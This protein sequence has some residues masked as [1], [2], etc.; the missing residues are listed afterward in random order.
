MREFTW[1]SRVGRH[2]QQSSGQRE[3]S[4]DRAPNSADCDCP[5]CPN[6][7]L[8]PDTLN[9]ECPGIWISQPAT[10]K[11]EIS[12]ERRKIGETP[13]TNHTKN[14]GMTLKTNLGPCLQDL[15][16]NQAVK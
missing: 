15:K 16:Q 12:S 3:S 11:I 1:R 13:M 4:W 7:Q 5:L 8:L 6:T 2:L 9:N 14:D 10:A